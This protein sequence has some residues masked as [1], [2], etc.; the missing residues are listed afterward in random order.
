WEFYSLPLY[1]ER[2]MLVPRPETAHLVEAVLKTHPRQVADICT[3]TGCVAVAVAKWLPNAAV[4][5]TDINPAAVALARKN[6][7]RHGLEERVRVFEGDLLAPV[8]DFA[9][10][11]AICANPP[12][13][14]DEAWATLSRNITEYEDP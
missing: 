5:G 12:Y 1:V 2:P 14:E 11:D 7:A 9:P 10:F 3:G 4:V 13:V 6:A 8:R